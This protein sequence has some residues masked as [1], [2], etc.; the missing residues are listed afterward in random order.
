MSGMTPLIQNGVHNALS[1]TT[2]AAVAFTMPTRPLPTHAI[3]NVVGASVRWRADGT[4]PTATA[5]ILV[6]A[7]GNIEFMDA[8]F[9]YSNI[10]ERI[11]FI[12]ISGT[13]TIEAAF[14]FG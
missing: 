2:G 11:K 7:N 13:A 6:P 10:I 8:E 5:G 12:G 4:S 1:A 14:F 9:N 3:I